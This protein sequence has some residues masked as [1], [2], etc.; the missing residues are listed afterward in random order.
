VRLREIRER[1]QEV[2]RSIALEGCYLDVTGRHAY[3]PTNCYP[4]LAGLAA[5][6]GMVRKAFED[7]AR[8]SRVPVTVDA[9]IRRGDVS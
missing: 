2:G 3:R 9:P 7:V 6:R 5:S 8:E 4:L 1:A